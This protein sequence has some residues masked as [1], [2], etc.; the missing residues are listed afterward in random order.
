MYVTVID[1]SSA[2]EYAERKIRAKIG[3]REEADEDGH[4]GTGFCRGE[5]AEGYGCECG[6]EG[7]ELKWAEWI[8]G[9]GGGYV[10]IRIPGAI[11][12]TI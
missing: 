11:L 8:R 9:G 12:E 4:A 3:G 2:I 10:F 1:T 7:L 5:A 6:G